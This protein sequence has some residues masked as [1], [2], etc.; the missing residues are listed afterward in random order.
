MKKASIILCVIILLAMAGLPVQAFGGDVMKGTPTVDG[1]LD[2][3]YKQSFSY[4]INPQDNPVYITGIDA[5][6]VTASATTYF[7]W[8]DNYIYICVDIVDTSI[9]TVGADVINGQDYT[10]DNDVTELWFAAP[11]SDVLLINIDAFNTRI[12]GSPTVTGDEGYIAKVG[13]TSYGYIAEF[14]IPHFFKVGD[15]FLF[16]TQVNNMLSVDPHQLACYGAQR[17]PYEFKLLATEVTYP[18]P[19]II[20]EVVEIDP[21]EITVTVTPPPATTSPQTADAVSVA[22]LMLGL[23]GLAVLGNK[24]KK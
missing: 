8:D 15:I 21:G 6:D 10:W 9:V 3:I 1:V 23:S 20:E 11:G 19:E 16:S 5:A 12:T 2:D 14:A 22:I 13:L 7:L 24:R 18:V 4:T 17:A